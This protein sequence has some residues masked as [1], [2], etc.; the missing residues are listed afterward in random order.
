[1]LLVVAVLTRGVIPPLR[2]AFEILGNMGRIQE[3]ED[4]PF[5]RLGELT[6]TRTH[7]ITL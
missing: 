1:M 5:H 2:I 6:G 4:A 7:R 3:P